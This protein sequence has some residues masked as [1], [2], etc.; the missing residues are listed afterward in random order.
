MKRELSVAEVSE[1][2]VGAERLG[3]VDFVLNLLS[4]LARRAGQGGH[5]LRV[6]GYSP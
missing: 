1:D 2:G 4:L 3:F 5:V 6:C